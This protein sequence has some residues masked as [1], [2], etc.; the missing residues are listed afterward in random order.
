MASMFQVEGRGVVCICVQWFQFPC[1]GI[2][3]ALPGVFMCVT[4]V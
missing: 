2:N 1:Q 3:G 4:C